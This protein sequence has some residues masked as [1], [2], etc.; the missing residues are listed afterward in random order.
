[1]VGQTV[2]HYRVLEKLGGGGMG[3]VYKALD[4]RLG[5]HVALKFLP[6]EFSKDRQA[7]ERFKREARAAS[8][9]NHPH[10]CTIHDIGEHQGQPYIVMELLEGHTLKHLRGDPTL[11]LGILLEIA[12]QIADALTAA[13][14]KGIIHRDIKPANIFAARTGQAKI[15]DFGLAKLAPQRGAQQVTAGA[16]TTEDINL[17]SPGTALGTVAYMSPEQARGEELDARTDIFSFGVVLYE[18]AT[19]R[20]AFTGRSTAVIFEAILNRTPTS[21]V[22]INPDLPDE[23]EHIINKALEKDRT[24][25]Y[26]SA[27]EL[28]ADLN[29]LK[30]DTDSSRAVAA[31]TPAATTAASQKDLGS[32]TAV[33]AA[34]L[35]RH[36]KGLLAGLAV[37]VLLAGGLSYSLYRSIVPAGGEVIT[38]VAVL[39]FENLSADPDAEYLSDGIT[40]SLINS[41]S[42]LQNLS[43]VISHSSVSRYKGQEIDLKAIG[44]ELD[45]HAVLQGKVV[46]RGEMFF[47][48][49][50]LVDIHD[51]SHIW[52]EQYN[53]RMADI[54]AVQ[55]EIAKAITSNLRLKL[56]GEDE[57]RLTKR[58]TENTEAYRAYLKGRYY[59]N[60]RT[61]EGFKKAI[62]SFEEAIAEDPN[63]ALAYAGLA[64]TY[65]LLTRYSFLPA[66]EGYPKAQAAAKKALGIDDQLA[67]A[68]TS[69]AFTKR[70]YDWAWNDAEREYQLA[71]QISP[72]Y[73]TAHHWYAL[74][75]VAATGRLE[76]AIAEIERAQE[77]DPLSLIINTNLAWTNYFARRYPE[78][79]D[80]FQKTLEMD[81]SFSLAHLRLGL[82]YEQEKMFEEAIKEFQEAVNLS[83]ANPEYIAALGHANAVAGRR[84][85]AFKIVDELTKLSEQR[86]V[87]AYDIAVIYSGLGDS[88]QAFSWL[89]KAYQERS[90][91]LGY[92][93]ID[94]RFD[95]LRADPRFKSLLRRMNF[96]E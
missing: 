23:L 3:V 58:Y 25:R 81:Q 59:W 5:R 69:L 94:P 44:R 62:E 7:V 57:R 95:P 64:D 37:L 22:R 70:Y 26:Q 53:R 18:M 60:K 42:Q 14:A 72:G 16:A 77:L 40:E 33:I 84:G 92:L 51:N 96:P 79:I 48:S 4:T 63:Y 47:I 21:P 56:S 88:E 35:K 9:L 93:K 52:G 24:L 54:F 30:R 89:E 55:E 41:L 28:R 66:K 20:Q 76:E 43:R 73:A 29:R 49:V 87:Q 46:R 36:K 12:I 82:T 75:L 39:P 27:A 80:Q 85:E 61:E 34:V 91:N 1:M 11:D 38:S 45:V 6:E 67:E 10:I 68:H 31:G 78:A 83:G 65:A 15:L 71:I 50:E 19:G 86:N 13:H 17:T 32:D 2:S 90:S 74:Y 8:A